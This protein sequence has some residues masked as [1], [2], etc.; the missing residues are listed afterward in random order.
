[1]SP[2]MIEG[3]HVE[4][5]GLHGAVFL[6]LKI[7][8]RSPDDT[9]LFRAGHT[10]GATAKLGGSAVSDFGEYKAISILHDQVN[11]PQP[12]ME[13]A[14]YRFKATDPQK[15]FRHPFPSL[16]GCAALIQFFAAMPD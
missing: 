1:M 2:I 7:T 5:A 13:I 16:T 12:A 15:R 11:F 14:R 9:G 8:L 10:F 3:D 4:S 6:I